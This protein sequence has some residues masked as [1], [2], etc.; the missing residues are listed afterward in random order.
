MAEIRLL[1]I[2]VKQQYVKDEEVND[3]LK[4]V[5]GIIRTDKDKELYKK[6]LDFI[7]LFLNHLIRDSSLGLTINL[8]NRVNGLKYFIIK[9]N[10][11]EYL[12]IDEDLDF[13][14]DEEANSFISKY[15]IED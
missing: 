4:E 7:H 10:K 3:I 13:D 11:G 14:F 2:I 8:L 9:F 15:L 1:D 12:N 6:N 5:K